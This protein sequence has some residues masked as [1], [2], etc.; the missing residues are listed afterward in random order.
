[1]SGVGH[2]LFETKVSD[3]KDRLPKVL[4]SLVNATGLEYLRLDQVKMKSPN[5]TVQLQSLLTQ[6]PPG[7]LRLGL[8]NADL[9]SDRHQ[10]RNAI[11]TILD[12]VRN[13]SQIQSVELHHLTPPHHLSLRKDRMEASENISQLLSLSMD[14][15]TLNHTIAI[16][17]YA[18]SLQVWWQ[19]AR[20]RLLDISGLTVGPLQKQSPIAR[21]LVKFDQKQLTLQEMF[22]SCTA[23]IDVGVNQEPHK[24]N[25]NEEVLILLLQRAPQLRHLSYSLDVDPLIEDT[26]LE[27]FA[28]DDP[29]DPF[30]GA[31]EED[32]HE[33]VRLSRDCPACRSEG[34]IQKQAEAIFTHGHLSNV[35]GRCVVKVIFSCCSVV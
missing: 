15:P 14:H 16:S 29:G 33:E 25:C 27:V 6:L 1:M 21:R 24:C 22:F 28:P 13:H 2:Q 35:A 8:L 12:A 7:I 23:L 5:A 31:S 9:Y 17:S 34:G 3:M 11:Y 20:L 19:A 18:K 10:E 4:E 30:S 32:L 26:L